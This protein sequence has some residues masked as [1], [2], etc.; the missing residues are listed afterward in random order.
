MH[1][2][3]VMGRRGMVAAAHPL[4]SLAGLD[5]LRGGGNAIDAAV[6]TNAV[7]NVVQPGACGIDGDLFCLIY[8]AKSGQ[9]HFL[10]ASGRSAMGA[11]I[12]AYRARG[13]SSV[14]TRG[15]LSVN[16]PG[17]V[18]GWHQMLTRFGTM[19]FSELLAPA[20]E[21]AVDGFP[22]SHVMAAAIRT[23]AERLQPHESW[24]RT[25]TPNGHLP[26]PGELFRQPDLGRSLQAIAREGRDAFYHGEI[27][28]A[29]AALSAELGGFLTEQDMAAHQSDWGA[30][31]TGTYRGYTIYE[32]PPNTQ[33]VAAIEAAHIVSGWPVGEWEDPLR[34]HRF[35]EAKRLAFADRDRYISDPA[36]T[37]IPIERLTSQA[38]ADQLRTQIGEQA[39]PYGNGPMSRGGTTYFAVA[40]RHG[41]L[42]SCV[43]SLFQG[44]GALVVPEGTGIALHNRGSYFSL[45]PQ[46][47]N[48][49]APHKRTM[50]TLIASM[51]F[52]DDRPWLVFGTMGGDGQ[53]QTHLQVFSNLID[54]GMNIQEAIEAPR[55]VHGAFDGSA[56]VL[57]AEVL[58]METRF[59]PA[60]VEALRARGHVVQVTTNWDS[61]MGHAQG[62]RVENGVYMG[63]AD[64]RGDGYAMGY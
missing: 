48:H 37:Q 46:H 16:V 23:T 5:V 8:E 54:Y 38:Y 24:L 4:A 30:P 56:E 58:K 27:A 20:I 41:N 1:R 33:G 7:L 25:Y 60:A 31:I 59:S 22:L 57:K 55:W 61:L 53:P 32:T 14:P 34:L 50:H 19:T 63:G 28:R 47:V 40:D 29:L 17:C 42:V 45:D 36:S 64:P 13:L 12:E 2:P 52:K 43:Q 35:V 3:V 6:A 51:V 9:V 15:I 49:L 10:N 62:I 21:Y 39:M 18:D 26:Q 11:S 44:F